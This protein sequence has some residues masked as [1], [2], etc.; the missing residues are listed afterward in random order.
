MKLFLPMI[1]KKLLTTTP[2]RYFIRKF[3]INLVPRICAVFESVSRVF[4]KPVLK[5]VHTSDPRK[6][7]QCF[8][9]MF[10]FSTFKVIYLLFFREKLVPKIH[11][12]QFHC[13]RRKFCDLRRR[14]SERQNIQISYQIKVQSVSALVQKRTH[15]TQIGGCIHKNK[16]QTTTFQR[17]IIA[18]RSFIFARC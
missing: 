9:Q 2:I 12:N 11:S 5:F 14:I 15:I 10:Y 8:L 6:R 1:F 16:R 3:F 18:T 13:H 4:I 7:S 17:V